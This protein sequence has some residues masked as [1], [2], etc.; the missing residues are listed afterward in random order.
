MHSY[1]FLSLYLSFLLCFFLFFANFQFS[2]LEVLYF[3]PLQFHRQRSLICQRFSSRQLFDL[4][5]VPQEA[6]L[7]SA[8]RVLQGSS[9]NPFFALSGTTASANYRKEQEL[10]KPRFPQLLLTYSSLCIIPH[11]LCFLCPAYFFSC[12][13]CFPFLCFLISSSSSKI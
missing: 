9:A 3:R 5:A 6:A 13:F 10:R 8:G 12:S 7:R 1:L 4:S 11:G 2:G